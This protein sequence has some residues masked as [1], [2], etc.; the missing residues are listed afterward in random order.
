MEMTS[1]RWKKLIGFVPQ[2]DVMIR[3]L[4]VRDNIE[5]AANY[6]LPIEM[7][8]AER[9]I[10]VNETLIDLGIEHVQFSVIGNKT[11]KMFSQIK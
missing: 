11:L 10:V 3:Q 1:C 9:T 5:F 8:R 2:E 6:R 4:T 7:S